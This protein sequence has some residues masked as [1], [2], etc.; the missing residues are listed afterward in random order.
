MDPEIKPFNAKEEIE[1]LLEDNKI[2]FTN[3]GDN[4]E[5]LL[6][7]GLGNLLYNELNEF[8]KK[9]ENNGFYILKVNNP[10]TKQKYKTE[11]KFEGG[12]EPEKREERKEQ[13]LTRRGQIEE[14]WERQPFFYDK[15][16]I[17]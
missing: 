3:K 2:F 13:I 11:I 12:K 7:V 9:K 5:D 17:F 6:S 10:E 16:K 8:V 14:F 4:Y 1:R 15:S